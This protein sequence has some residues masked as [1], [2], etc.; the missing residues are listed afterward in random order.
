MG[1]N[2]VKNNWVEYFPDLR[3]S[4]RAQRTCI[5]VSAPTDK[6]PSYQR[7]RAD[8]S[9]FASFPRGGADSMDS[10]S[11]L[12]WNWLPVRWVPEACRI[13]SPSF[14]HPTEPSSYG[15]FRRARSVRASQRASPRNR[16]GLSS[17]SPLNLGLSTVWKITILMINLIVSA[18]PTAEDLFSFQCRRNKKIFLPASRQHT[19]DSIELKLKERGHRF[20]LYFPSR[21]LLS[22]FLYHN[23]PHYLSRNSKRALDE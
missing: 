13:A 11:A 19:L 23:V 14:C 22:D 9:A 18:C 17:Q 1:I 6:I 10:T 15:C 20:F 7:G 2:I 5:S 12:V 16:D 3:P 21:I 8:N 4:K